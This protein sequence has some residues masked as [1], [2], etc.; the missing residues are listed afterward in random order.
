LAT[1]RF[2]FWKPLNIEILASS[3]TNPALYFEYNSTMSC[4]FNWI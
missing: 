2:G 4:S 1:K 3:R